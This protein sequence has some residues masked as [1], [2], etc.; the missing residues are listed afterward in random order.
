[1]AVL[2]QRNSANRQAGRDE[3]GQAL[4]EFAVSATVLIV[5]VMGLI[6]F[7]RAIYDQEVISNLTREGS[8]L[9]AHGQGLANAANAVVQ[10]SDLANFGSSSTTNGLVIV[11]QITNNGTAGAP[12]C[13]VTSQQQAPANGGLA[14]TSKIGTAGGAAT[15]ASCSATAITTI[16]QPGQTVYA[17]EV[18]Y[19]FSPVTPIGNFLKIALPSQLYDV[20]YFGGL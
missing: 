14:A 4:L 15:L 9:A 19:S 18:F 1:V 12:N 11:S 16:P 7:S 3:A 8:S 2:R 5:L 13:V 20:A 10:G 6:D 17:T